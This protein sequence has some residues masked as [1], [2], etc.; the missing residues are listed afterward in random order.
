M[1]IHTNMSHKASSDEQASEKGLETVSII[2]IKITRRSTH[3]FEIHRLLNNTG[4]VL[5]TN[6][7]S[8]QK[9]NTD[10][11]G[12]S[13]DTTAASMQEYF[14]I[15]HILRTLFQKRNDGATHQKASRAQLNFSQIQYCITFMSQLKEHFAA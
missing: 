10:S 13:G 1:S 9:F 15:V 11:N 12:C 7:S 5:R 3:G 8:N 6:T 4:K 2:E 14:H